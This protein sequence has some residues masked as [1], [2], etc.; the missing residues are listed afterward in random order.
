MYTPHIGWIYYLYCLLKIYIFILYN[1]ELSNQ[2]G[3]GTH[4]VA[5]FFLS[6]LFISVILINTKTE[7]ED[8]SDI[9]NI[10]ISLHNSIR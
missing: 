7:S 10:E 6:R 1:G 2:K 5:I 3:V 9:F 8:L 4:T